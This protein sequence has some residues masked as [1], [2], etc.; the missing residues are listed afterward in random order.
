MNFRIDR[1]LFEIVRFVLALLLL[2]I[3]VHFGIL[4]P[5]GNYSLA[6]AGIFEN[7]V[8]Y[9]IWITLITYSLYR[10]TVI[11]ARFRMFAENGNETL[12][13]KHARS[14]SF[15]VRFE[16]ML[17]A[18]VVFPI[19]FGLGMAYKMIEITGLLFQIVRHAAILIIA[20]S[21]AFIYVEN[22]EFLRTE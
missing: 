21:I 9:V 2:G 13:K 10:L 20:V 1:F 16:L 14:T 11:L 18:S 3:G 4:A 6:Y 12:G 7:S 15:Y 5:R 22:L 17:L 19:I 8:Q